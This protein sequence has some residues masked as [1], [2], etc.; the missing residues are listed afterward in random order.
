M[1]KNGFCKQHVLLLTLSALLLSFQLS[2]A[3]D[4]DLKA[5]IGTL[6]DSVNIMRLQIDS[7][8]LQAPGLGDYMTTIQLHIAKLWYAL[9]AANWELANYEVN[10][11]NETIDGARSLH[12]MKNNVNTAGVLQ[13]VQDT[14]VLSMHNAIS[15]RAISFSQR[16]IMRRSMPATDATNRRAMVSFRLRCRPRRRSQTKTGM[17][18]KAESR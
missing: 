11:L 17:Y 15:S 14:Q 12:A 9:S 10:E 13:S 6:R 2:S 4:Q 18:T 8:K 16:P 5:A 1:I 7:L 3:Q